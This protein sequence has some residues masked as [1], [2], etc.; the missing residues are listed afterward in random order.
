[1]TPAPPAGCDLEPVQ[2]PSPTS[3]GLAR[4]PGRSVGPRAL[5]CPENLLRFT[6]MAERQH[7]DLVP[8][9]SVCG[10]DVVNGGSGRQ[11]R[12]GPQARLVAPRPTPA[13]RAC[14]N[15]R[16]ISGDVAA[17]ARLWAI[18]AVR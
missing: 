6:R 18:A 1:V 10:C 12:L 11:V 3:T 5:E 2:A 14:M 9:G 16:S 15:A 4:R 17:C 13:G 7:F 8:A